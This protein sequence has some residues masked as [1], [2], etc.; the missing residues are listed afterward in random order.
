MEQVKRFELVELLV[1]A[2]TFGRVT[3]Q[4]IPQL[5]NQP[6][7]IIQITSIKVY[8]VTSYSNSQQTGTLP[9]MP[10][11]EIPKGVLVLYVNGEESIKMI[12]LSQMIAI[13]DFSSPFQ[14]ELFG[15]DQLKNVDFDKS[16]V[17]FSSATVANAYVIPFGISYI[18]FVKMGANGS[19]NITG[20][21]GGNWVQG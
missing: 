3:F 1:P 17:Q 8:P 15:F 12:P 13:N 21:P 6:D 2:S 20:A 10:V 14:Q 4:T 5:R 16:Y 7:Q 18:R 9:G 19:P 11:A